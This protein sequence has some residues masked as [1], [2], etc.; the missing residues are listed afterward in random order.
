MALPS[1]HS[2][3]AQQHDRQRVSRGEDD[4]R[5]DA[6][7]TKLGV[8]FRCGD[9]VRTARNRNHRAHETDRARGHIRQAQAFA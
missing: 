2:P 3:G 6:E 8:A 5:D 1:R 7:A 4:E 9:S